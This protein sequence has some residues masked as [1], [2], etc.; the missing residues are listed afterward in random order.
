MHPV[1]CRKVLGVSGHA[2]LGQFAS[3][4]ALALGS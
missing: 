4:G 1:P 2:E 3:G